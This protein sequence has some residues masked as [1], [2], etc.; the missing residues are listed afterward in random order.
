MGVGGGATIT[1]PPLGIPSPPLTTETDHDCR[2]LSMPSGVGVQLCTDLQT[3]KGRIEVSFSSARGRALFDWTATAHV[4]LS[5][6]APIVRAV[7]GCAVL[8][9]V[10]K[11]TWHK[12][13]N[14][15]QAVAEGDS[16]SI[17]SIVLFPDPTQKTQ[18]L[19]MYRLGV[20][21]RSSFGLTYHFSCRLLGS[22]CAHHALDF[23]RSE[24]T[25]FLA[26]S[27]RVK[28]MYA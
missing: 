19:R 22:E 7:A 17:T 25:D 13:R 26:V 11:S 9:G 15:C 20:S 14:A 23:Q 2:Y 5:P 28:R 21:K 12:K 6:A 3:Q 27:V 18:T 1:C 10:H 8:N 24:W 4:T 16:M